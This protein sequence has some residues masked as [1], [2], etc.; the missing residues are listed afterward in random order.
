MYVYLLTAHQ[1]KKHNTWKIIIIDKRTSREKRKSSMIQKINP[2]LYKRE[3]RDK[4]PEL[5]F[6]I[7]DRATVGC[8][9][10]SHRADL[11][12]T[13]RNLDQPVT[14]PDKVWTST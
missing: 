3:A 12:W 2:Y 14:L 9:R 11:R 13:H 8:L 5:T 10:W 6:T 4:Q 1:R 7:T